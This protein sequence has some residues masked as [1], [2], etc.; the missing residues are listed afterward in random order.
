MYDDRVE[1]DTYYTNIYRYI[2]YYLSI[3]THTH[4]QIYTDKI[5]THSTHKQ[6]RWRSVIVHR[7]RK[8]TI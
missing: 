1:G 6:E 7:G 8:S 3:Y 5:Q 2:I 4:T